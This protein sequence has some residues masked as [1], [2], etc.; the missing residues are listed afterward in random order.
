ME[1]GLL[2]IACNALRGLFFDLANGD[3]ISKSDMTLFTLSIVRD[4]GQSIGKIVRYELA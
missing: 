1:P 2:A 4:S 3:E